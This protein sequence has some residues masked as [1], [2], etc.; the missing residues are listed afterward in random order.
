MVDDDSFDDFIDMRLAGYRVLPIGDVHEGGPEADGQVVGIHHVL[1]TVLGKVI[2]E[3]KEVSHDHNDHAGQGDEDLLDW[4]HPVSWVLQFNSRYQILKP[5]LR[6]EWVFQ[7]SE[8][9]F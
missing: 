5:F 7:S 9:Q 8:I 2:E 4:V 1:I 3:S 6:K